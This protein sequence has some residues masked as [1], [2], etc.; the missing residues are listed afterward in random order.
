MAKVARTQIL[1][2]IPLWTCHKNELYIVLS[3]MQIGFRGDN[4]SHN[5]KLIFNFVLNGVGWEVKVV[6]QRV[7]LKSDA[8]SFPR[9]IPTYFRTFF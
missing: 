9:T 2:T 6:S 4:K 3:H 7:I 8:D 5:L 1:L